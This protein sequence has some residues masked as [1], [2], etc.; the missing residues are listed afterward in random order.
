MGKRSLIVGCLLVLVSGCG[1]THHFLPANPIPRKEWQLS[2]NWHYDFDKNV[3]GLIVPEVSGYAGM[4]QSWNLGCGVQLPFLVSHLSAAKYYD[5]SQASRWVA[6]THLNQIF[7]AN[8]NP[9]LEL[10]AMRVESKRTYAHQL[11]I[12]IAY[13]HGF[14]PGGPLSRGSLNRYGEIAHYRFMP[15]LRYGITGKDISLSFMHYHGKTSASLA[16]ARQTMDKTNDTLF[17]VPHDSVISFGAIDHHR[18]SRY[19]M[20]MWGIVKTTGDTIYLVAYNAPGDVGTPFLPYEG[21]NDYVTFW[22]RHAQNVVS[23]FVQDGEAE[24]FDSAERIVL[25]IPRAIKNWEEGGDIILTRFSPE[26]VRVV[27]SINDFLIDYS[28]GISINHRSD[29]FDK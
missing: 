3:R 28:M 5:T 10:G 2:I 20:G 15:V 7:G 19:H 1:T 14:C 6:Y 4:G 27:E 18:Y 8:D 12:G 13:G 26:A 23:A 24:W 22:S 25:S 29:W 16:G 17:Y 9:F 21:R 11:A